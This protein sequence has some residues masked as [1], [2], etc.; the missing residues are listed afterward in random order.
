MRGRGV[1]DDS[2]FLAQDT[3][4]N[5]VDWKTW[6]EGAG[7]EVVSEAQSWVLSC[8]LGVVRLELVSCHLDSGGAYTMRHTVLDM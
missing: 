8:E 7:R 4:K 3:G 6:G 1:K 2:T 5:E